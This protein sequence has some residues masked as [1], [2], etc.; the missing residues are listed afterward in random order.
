MMVENCRYS[1][2]PPDGDANVPIYLIGLQ[3]YSPGQGHRQD[4]WLLEV[5]VIYRDRILDGT[6]RNSYHDICIVLADR[7]FGGDVD[8]V[9]GRVEKV[10]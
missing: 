8:A 10:M 9:T 1:F 5:P 7:F 3:E 2:V 4:K 6:C